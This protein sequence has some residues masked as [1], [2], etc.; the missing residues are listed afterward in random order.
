MIKIQENELKRISDYVYKLTGIVLDSTKAYLAESRLFPLLNEYDC[1]SYVQ[2]QQ[3]AMADN[4]KAIEKK[5]IDNITTN[6][7]YFFRDKNPFELLKN[8]ILPETF[9]RMAANKVGRPKMR[10]WS[11]ACST[12]QEIYSIG[13]VLKELLG[14]L[15]SMNVSLFGTDISDAAIQKASMGRYSKFEVERGLE[16]SRINRYFK[17]IS[18]NQWQISDEI[19]ALASYQKVNI[20]KPFT[21]LG[22]FDIILVRNVAIY[23]DQPNK[24]RLFEQI[25]NQLNPHGSLMIGS[26][27]SLIGISQRFE[28]RAYHNSIY[29]ELVR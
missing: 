26:T 6:E 18:S 27:E 5:I 1:T 22:K 8:K 9:D 10:I 25:A 13:I 28:K 17:A 16:A 19:R 24:I 21:N 29:Y 7:T 12:G 23:F 11:A 15:S 14:N 2:L 4:T 3:K 20:L